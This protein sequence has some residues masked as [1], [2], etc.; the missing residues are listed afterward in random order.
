MIAP[1]DL[2][3]SCVA[4]RS[5]ASQALSTS[6][7]YGVAQACSAG[8]LGVLQLI[9]RCVELAHKALL[10]TP[11]PDAPGVDVRPALCWYLERR[12]QDLLL[13]LRAAQTLR[14]T[15]RPSPE[16]CRLV[17]LTCENWVT[18]INEFSRRLAGDAERIGQRFGDARPPRLLAVTPGLSD[19]HYCGR[20]VH[21]L[22][23]EGFSLVYK[24]RAVTIEVQFQRFVRW[25]GQLLGEEFRVID[26]LESEDYSWCE[27][28]PFEPFNSM[29]DAQRFFARAGILLFVCYLLGVTDCHTENTNTTRDGPVLVDA[30]TVLHPDFVPKLLPWRQPADTVL[31]PGLV[32]SLRPLAL[33]FSATAFMVRGFRQAYEAVLH[34]PR[35]RDAVRDRM[36]GFS[37]GRSRV[38]F[39]ATSFYHETLFR[40]LSPGA[41]SSRTERHLVLQAIAQPFT[42]PDARRAFGPLIEAEVVSL[43]NLDVP[44]FFA[45]AMGT[46]VTDGHSLVA[47]DVLERGGLPA[48][49]DR[50][51]S[52]NHTELERMRSILQATLM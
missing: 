51:D 39:R 2:P 26:M 24:P 25:F 34:D 19:P 13:G 14:V 17:T 33:E 31:R 40:S 8:R 3:H 32:H 44:C 27:Y 9:H 7:F 10:R 11:F 45:D 4:G 50:L 46:K 15:S 43:E 48:A 22:K 38:V 37:G 35:L 49:L 1:R 52:L 16:L 36:A 20:T 42:H 6:P 5:D 21:L 29:D 41:L 12:L 28:I 47:A 23:F 30:E 18:E